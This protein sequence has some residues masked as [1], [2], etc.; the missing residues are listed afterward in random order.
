LF[1]FLPRSDVSYV[2]KLINEKECMTLTLAKK[3]IR[4]VYIYEHESVQKERRGRDK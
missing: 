1:Y 2:F 4:R 3:K